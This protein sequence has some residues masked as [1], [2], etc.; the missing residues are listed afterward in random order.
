LALKTQFRSIS[1]INTAKIRFFFSLNIFFCYLKFKSILAVR[2]WQTE[3]LRVVCCVWDERKIFRQVFDFASGFSRV[4]GLFRGKFEEV[5]RS[6]GPFYFKIRYFLTL[7]IPG[8][9][10]SQI[11][12]QNTQI[13]T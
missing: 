12:T 4:F 10:I 7:L 11:L 5:C 2:M 13:L 1:V 8:H 9:Q 6:T 3:V